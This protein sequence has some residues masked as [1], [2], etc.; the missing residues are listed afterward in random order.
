MQPGTRVSFMAEGG[1]TKIGVVRAIRIVDGNHTYAEVKVDGE[2][3][4]GVRN[5]SYVKSTL[6][7][8]SRF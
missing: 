7:T 2:Q 5:V 3:N 1:T 6:Y 4:P 8:R